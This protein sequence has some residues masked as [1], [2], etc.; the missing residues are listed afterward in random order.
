MSDRPAA[1][2]GTPAC[3]A[4]FPSWPVWDH[5]ERDGLLAVLDAGGWWSGN[6]NE[7]ATFATEFAAFQGARFGLA[8]TNGTHTLEAA[9]AACDI[10]EGDEVIVP[11]ITFI[12]SASAVLAVNATPVLVDIDPDTLCIDPAAAEAA[13]TPRTRAIVAV[14][15]AGA[16]ADLDALTEL[17]QRHGLRL[18]EDC[19]HAHG[20][21]WRGRGVGSWGDFGS[22]SMQRSKLLT[23][24]EGGALICN[25]EVLRDRAWA[26]ADCGRVKGEWFYH[27]A[28]YGSNLRMTEWQGAV[29]RAQLQRFPEQHAV[30]N[31]N[32][33]ALNAALDEIPGIRTPRRDPRMDSQGNYCFVFHYDAAEFAGLPLRS[34]EAALAAEGVPMGVSYPSLGELA[35]FRE[36][37]FGPRLRASAPH[38]ADADLHLP[39]AEHAASTTVW[40]QHRLLLA[41]RDHVLEVAGAVAKLQRHA[42]ALVA[43]A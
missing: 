22:F 40:L 14:H 21:S 27:H 1:L 41:P 11:G 13:I 38:Y 32:A 24:G 29:L 26:Y 34:F 39:N 15:V 36:R 9:L 4:P 25:D 31:A 30:R 20:T 5:T 10:G 18:I 3:T 35:V 23:A 28:G 16:A 42:A 33:V 8:F 12:A 7:A 17:C 6:G 37:R 43:T 2:G 19:A